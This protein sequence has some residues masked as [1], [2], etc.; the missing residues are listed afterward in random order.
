[1][2]RKNHPKAVAGVMPTQ[3]NKMFSLLSE[4]LVKVLN[5]LLICSD[6]LL[7]SNGVDNQSH[8][9]HLHFIK[10]LLSHFPSI[11]PSEE[12][13]QDNVGIFHPVAAKWEDRRKVHFH[14][15]VKIIMVNQF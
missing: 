5:I 15:D 10:V 4:I 9:S 1:M 14:R 8:F 11:S 6:L 2:G 13:P 12:F 7:E 3:L